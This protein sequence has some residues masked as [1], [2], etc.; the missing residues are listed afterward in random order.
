MVLGLCVYGDATGIVNAT[1]E[2]PWTTKLEEA[3]EMHVAIMQ[4]PAVAL[5]RCLPD[6]NQCKVMAAE[7]VWHR[8]G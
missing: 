1:E 7:Q 8:T 3:L 4:V 5:K 2:Y 6:C